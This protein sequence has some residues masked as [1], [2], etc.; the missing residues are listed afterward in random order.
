MVIPRFGLQGIPTSMCMRWLYLQQ[1][2]MR[3]RF[4]DVMHN[5]GLLRVVV[6]KRTF[7]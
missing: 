7:N 2:P 6:V 1:S 4:V 3:A 5:L